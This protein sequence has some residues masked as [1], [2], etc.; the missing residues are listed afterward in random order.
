[1]HARDGYSCFTLYFSLSA[2]VFFSLAVF[3]F[4]HPHVSGFYG[5]CCLALVISA[6]ETVILASPVGS[7][8]KTVCARRHGAPLA[9]RD[10]L[11]YIHL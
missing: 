8:D 7:V 11:L 10:P 3:N 6:R 5:S 1:M 2:S 9:K 4:T